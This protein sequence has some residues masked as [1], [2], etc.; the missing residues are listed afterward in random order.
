V[1][2]IQTYIGSAYSSYPIRWIET[3]ESARAG[4][5][6]DKTT[7]KPVEKVA[8]P[9]SG[10]PR[11]ESGD[12]LDISPETQKALELN[13][14]ESQ[15]RSEETSIDSE[16]TV[17]S[18][19]LEKSEQTEKSGKSE[20][21][22]RSA[23]ATSSSTE[24]SS[25]GTSPTG[26][27]L[28]PEQ[29]Q[30]VTELKA[31]DLEV[32]AHELAHVLAGGAFVTGGPSYEYEVGPDGN[33]YAVGGSVGIDT[34]PI[35]G[36]PEATIAK[37]QVVA[38]AALAP[39]KPSG[40]D[41]KVAAAARQAEAQARSELVK[42]QSGQVQEKSSDESEPSASANDDAP[43]F[44]IVRSAD[45]TAESA[46][47]AKA[48]DSVMSSLVRPQSKSGSESSSSAYKAQSAMSLTT[49][50]FSAFA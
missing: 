24:T 14:A 35:E 11:S 20:K 2:S 42:L 36:N 43:V 10:K 8:D 9:D 28:T 39:A 3:P 18:E 48:E 27:E 13:Q 44:S 25:T 29:L 38:A 26:V 16:K 15:K 40:Q 30:Q 49:P 45:K 12:I 33:G 7:E 17:K 5:A 41:H 6:L 32:R 34:S 22:T 46:P 19:K 31:R 50:R 1:S 47:K 21:T 23:A 37:M 4:Y